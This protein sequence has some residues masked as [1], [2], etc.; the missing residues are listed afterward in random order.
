MML[1]VN[2]KVE[3]PS[4]D[5]QSKELLTTPTKNYGSDLTLPVN[6]L[7]KVAS[8]P[9]GLSVLEHLK[10]NERR[11]FNK[12]FQ[13]SKKKSIDVPKL[14]DAH[15]AG[16]KEAAK[17][18][19]ILTEG[20]SAKALAVS[21]LEVVGRDHYGVFPLRG[22]VLNVRDVPAKILGNNAEVKALC[23]IL[24][25][26]F[27]KQYKT[28]EEIA[29]LRYG[30]IMLMTD[31]DADGSHIKGLVINF[32]HYFWPEL[33][34]VKPNFMGMLLTPLVKG[35][36][37]KEERQFG[38]MNEFQQWWDEE[39][40]KG[41]RVKYYKGLGTSTAQEGKEYFKSLDQMTKLFDYEEGDGDSLDM[42]FDKSKSEERRAWLLDKFDAGSIPNFAPLVAYKDFV[43]EELIHFSAADN[44]RS[45]PNVVDG[46][47]P[48]QRKVLYACF[49]RNLKNEIKVAQLAGYIAE[50]TAYHHGEASLHTTIIGMGQDFVGSNNVNLLTPS[51]Q[52]GTRLTGGKDSASPR[53]I[54]T[55]LMP[56]TRMIYSDLDD[57]L[58]NYLEDD[59]QEIEPNYFV[60]VLPMLA[61]N[62]SHGIGTGWSTSIPP[63]NP[64]DV[65]DYIRARIKGKEGEIL[66]LM[67]WVKGF[68]GTFF[69]GPKG[70]VSRGIVNVV[71]KGEVEITELP[72]GRWTSDYKEF[73]VKL[74][75]K[76][77]I[78]GFTENH[79]TDGVYFDVLM[80]QS[81]LSKN[82]KSL[83]KF[84][85]LETSLYVT[86]MNAFGA[87]GVVMKYGRVEDII[88]EWFKF[89]Q[90]LYVTRKAE[91]LK[92]LQH[93]NEILENK[94]RFIDLVLKK[95]I[96]LL[97]GMPKGEIVDALVEKGLKG[98]SELDA[99]LHGREWEPGDGIYD[100]LFGM[101]LSSFT[102]EKI[103][104]MD[105]D[106]ANKA[107]S[108]EAVEKESI[109]DMW[110]RE[111]SEIEEVLCA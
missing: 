32:I 72:V 47:K 20:D 64:K 92:V 1:F 98:K 86:N 62:G 67:P 79:T 3:D 95:E 111:L 85:R 91:R 63:H 8:G 60:P 14:D 53:Y 110:D 41:W 104:A 39:P 28:E 69:E 36:K 84:F 81:V 25:L 10:R 71:D 89:R 77:D 50:Q 30:R 68:K 93:E 75:D 61:I 59:G 7:N 44:I 96:D 40:R 9:V 107:Q 56:H 21:G 74:K 108:L 52:F 49:K 54:F 55:R 102:R 65:I 78:K 43:N 105:K 29:T 2:G 34:R 35:F 6:F 66:P 90:E 45:I 5:S 18:T 17:C 109:E 38:S 26:D 100:Y 83:H 48:S 80:T 73:L 37:G 4:F 103:D 87:D 76:G 24:G 51:G 12:I 57:P 13:N 42:A 27:N 16:S 15:L 19:L 11:K 33:L 70:V 46:L 94:S 97:G 106:R 82:K 22:K 99:I 58:L 88:D 31:Q 23:T 101:N